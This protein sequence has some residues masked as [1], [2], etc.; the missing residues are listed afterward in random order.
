[1]LGSRHLATRDLEHP[2]F[3]LLPREPP[4][5]RDLLD[6]LTR[7]LNYGR[8]RSSRGFATPLATFNANTWAFTLRAPEFARSLDL[9]HLS[10]SDGR[11]GS[12]RYFA[13]A[14][15]CSRLRA[16]KL[17]AL[18][19]RVPSSRDPWISATCPPRMDGSDPLVLRHSR[20]GASNFW[21]STPRAPELTRS[22]DLCHLSSSDGRL[23]S[24]RSFATRDLERPTFGLLPRE[25]RAH[26]IPGSLPPVL[27][28]WTAQILSQPRRSRLGASNFWTSTPNLRGS[29]SYSR[30]LNPRLSPYRSNDCRV[31]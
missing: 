15:S 30:G 24:S 6:L 2:T 4:S 21:T 16:S 19:S 27:L 14:T 22:L 17:W 5:S 10:S 25:S 9:C 31:S 3:G 28:G 20:L 1:V 18:P 13:T 29:E 11:L 8:L 26:E 23:R 12:S 7:V